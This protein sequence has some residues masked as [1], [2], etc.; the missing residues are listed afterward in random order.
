MIPL[1]KI[2]IVLAT[3]LLSL[4]I[5]NLRAQETPAATET[6]ET[7]S[8]EPVKATFENAIHI[9]NQTVQ[10]NAKNELGT[11]IQHRFGVIKNRSDLFG[12][13]APANVRLGVN[14]GFTKDLTLGFGITKSKMQYDFEWKYKIIGQSKGGGS[15][16]TV[17]YY[18]DMAYSDAPSANFANQNNEV[19]TANRLSFYHEVMVARKFD[20]H[21][22]AQI[23]INY[24]HVN[25]VDSSVFGTH[26]RIGLSLLARYKFSPQSSVEFGYNQN[27]ANLDW[28]PSSLKDPLKSDFSLGYEV[29]TGSHQFQIFICAADNILNQDIRFYNT[30]DFF[31]KQIL[32]GFNITRQWGF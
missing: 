14:Y 25:L 3:F 11:L 15:P 6:T 5:Q 8:K 26:D 2:T 29:S 1:K 13:Y 24:T 16:V 32:I 22:S 7:S 10:T 28:Q 30:N 18:G 17:T 31:N 4:T 12:L 27:L 23:G 21:F 20:S 9:N 19:S